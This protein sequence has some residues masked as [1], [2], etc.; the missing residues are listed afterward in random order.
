MPRARAVCRLMTNS[1]LV[2][3]TTGRSAGLAT[4]ED[5]A[6]I[7]ADVMKDVREVGSV[8]HQTAGCHKFTDRISRGNPVARRQGGKLHAAV[9]KECVA[10]DEEGIR[11]LVRKGC[12]GRIDLADCTG[13]EDLDLQPDGVGGFLHLLQRGLSVIRRIDEHDASCLISAWRTSFMKL[14]SVRSRR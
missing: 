13:I 5:A 12:K 6:G 2:D 7:D 10:S 3:C 9:E 14:C 11:V 1:S 4:L 8:A